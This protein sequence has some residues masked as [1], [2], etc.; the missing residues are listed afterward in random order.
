MLAW[1]LRSPAN[2]SHHPLHVVAFLVAG[3]CIAAT[4]FAQSEAVALTGQVELSRLVDLVAQ[5]LHLS[6]DYDAAALKGAVTLRLD[7]AV[8]D[9]ELWTLVNRLLV[10]R[11]FTTVRVAGENA[12]SVVK[13]ADAPNL[14]AP[15]AGVV[16]AP[17]APVGPQPVLAPGFRVAVT[18]LEHRS[19]KEI[20]DTVGKV[21]SKPGG[22]ITPLG[23]AGLVMI[24]DLSPRVDQALE[25]IKVLDVPTSVVVREIPVHHL[26]APALAALVAQ[27]EAKRDLV[28]G[29]KVPGEVL[30]GP[31]GA[32]VLLI[33][34]EEREA[35]WK[36]LIGS[37][38]QRE[39][40]GTQTYLPKAFAVKD[41][42][43]LVE[44]TAKDQ[45]GVPPDDRFRV[46]ADE[47][48]G[49]LIVTATP[50]QHEQIAALVER[51][52]QSAATPAHPVRSYVI[53]NRPVKDVQAVL[54]D[55]LQAGVLESSTGSGSENTPFTPVPGTQPWP[56]PT[57]LPAGATPAAAT[58]TSAQPTN[59]TPPSPVTASNN[60]QR[61][62]RTSTSHTVTD[63]SAPQPDVYLT[64]DSSTNTLIAMAEPRVLAQIE[65]L[66]KTLD[67]RQPQVMLEV[68]VV[69]LTEAQTLDLGVEL[70]SISTYGDVTVRLASLFGLAVAPPTGG[71]TPGSGG[72]APTGSGF[73]GLI[74]SPGDFSVLIRALQTIN[75]GRTLSMPKVLVGNNEQGTLDSVLDVPFASTNAS[76]TVATTS[77]GG[78]KPAGTQ[79]SIKP[80]I[81]A[82]DLLN[83]N[84]SVSL[85]S[86][87][88]A[89]A[90]P[91]LP[92][93]RQENKVQSVASIPDGYTVA[94]GGI[95]L[96]TESTGISQVP[97][98]AQIPIVGELF[99]DRSKNASKTRFYVFIRASV[100]RSTSFE[101]L[102]YLSQ[103]EALA[104]GV[105]DG[106]PVVEPRVIR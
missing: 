21:L 51:L 25:L 47:L 83:L 76:T 60:G 91:N 28:S 78:S 97:G 98:I 2:P 82:G 89:A 56:P 106:F 99:K 72:T 52:N 3:L 86:F 14:A 32:S 80:Q 61:R 10:A 81:G 43:K 88:G 70:T 29:E 6:V 102:K 65:D 62:I 18:R 16:Q 73:T 101:D 45:P 33:C 9:Q 40:V 64:S 38:D 8:S 84:Y 50:S 90:N 69:S 71:G 42:A 37:L 12:Y 41:V 26:A 34:A 15:A 105:D 13:L 66:I 39:P 68:L 100:L 24:A 35:Y 1:M 96:Q 44:E 95:E 79:V 103:Q 30:A 94:V 27:V 63:T 31:G 54:Q 48:T 58:T 53:K 20:A 17:G 85:S 104:A 57:P 11:G 5:R 75:H 55:L 19:A 49:S 46:V 59:I 22:A 92:P 87:T 36:S 93:P 4:V 7:G 67:V 74:L 23:D 77:F